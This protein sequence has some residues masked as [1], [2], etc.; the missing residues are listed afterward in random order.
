MSNGGGQPLA[1]FKHAC[2][3][4]G[5]DFAKLEVIGVVG[6]EEMDKA[7]RE[8]NGQYVQQQGPFCRGVLGLRLSEQDPEHSG[9][10]MTLGD[11]FHTFDIAQHPTPRDVPRLRHG[12]LGSHTSRSRS[13]IMRHCANPTPTC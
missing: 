2:H 3:K 1:M 6:A 11:G 12:Q 8:G 5:I 13:P 10:F 9:V 7:F 4:A